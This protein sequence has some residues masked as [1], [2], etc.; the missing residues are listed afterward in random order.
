MVVF[1]NLE[2]LGWGF[3][4]EKMVVKNKKAQFLVFSAMFFL[5]LLIFIYSLETDNSYIVKRGKTNLLD[6]LMHQSCQIGIYSN[7]TNI[8]N[9]FSN[10]SSSVLSYC[11][12]FGNSCNVT[13]TLVMARVPGGNMSLLNYTHFDYAVDYTFEGYGYAGNF[14]C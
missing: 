1:M 10:F 4:I 8:Q 5:L 11:D 2:L 13:F 9:R 14:T 3:V 6:N 7:A 12:G